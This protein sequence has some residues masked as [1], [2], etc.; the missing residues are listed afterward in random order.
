MPFISDNLL[1]DLP[2]HKPLENDTWPDANN[3]KLIVTAKNCDSSSLDLL[4]SCLKIK[5]QGQLTFPSQTRDQIISAIKHGLTIEF[6]AEPDKEAIGGGQK[7]MLRGPVTIWMQGNELHWFVGKESSTQSYVIQDVAGLNHWAIVVNTTVDSAR[8]TFFKDGVEITNQAT[9]IP[10]TESL[11]DELVATAA[12]ELAIGAENKGWTGKL[13]HL[14]IWGTPLTKDQIEQ[15]IQRD[16]TAHAAFKATTRIEWRLVNAIDEPS[17][18][19][20]SNG[21]QELRLELGNATQGTTLVIPH[22]DETASS[23]KYHFCLVFRPGTISSPL[24]NGT[25]EQFIKNIG[26]KNPDWSVCLDKLDMQ[27]CI[28]FLWKGSDKEL[29]P[30]EKFTLLIPGV[31]AEPGSG[32]R[33][34]EVGLYYKNLQIKDSGLPNLD[35]NRAQ[36]LNILYRESSIHNP[37]L[38]VGVVGAPVVL[39]NGGET[40]LTL[41]V[42]NIKRDEDQNSDPLYFGSIGQNND[43]SP[44]LIL[45][46]EIIQPSFLALNGFADDNDFAETSL[47][48][49]FCSLE[50]TIKGEKQGGEFAWTILPKRV[51]SNDKVG[52]DADETVLIKL[53]NLKTTAPPGRSVLRLCYEDFD[54]YGEGE[55]EIP[56]DRVSVIPA[57]LTQAGGAGYG[58]AIGHDPRV[59]KDTPNAEALNEM[60][61]IKKVDGNGDAVLIEN[62]GNGTGLNVVQRDNGVL[63]A[64]FSGGTGVEITG[65]FIV[66]STNTCPGNVGI[67]IAP[68]SEKLKVQGNTAI[69]GN[70]SATTLSAAST[71]TFTGNVGIGIE[72]GSEKLTVQGNTAILGN[73]SATTL[74]AT[75]TS[76]FTGNV[77][78]GIAPGSET[79]KVQGNTAITGNFS[80]FSGG[81]IGIGAT[82]LDKEP[83]VI[84]AQGNQE[85]LIAFENPSGQK[86]WHIE[87]NYDGNNPG[88]NFVE[89]G[90][91]DFRLFLKAGGNIGI[92]TS[93]PQ[94]KLH[95]KDGNLRIDSGE[96]KSCRPITLIPDID[97]TGDKEVVI[98]G[99]LKV[100]GEIWSNCYGDGWQKIRNA[101]SKDGQDFYM[102]RHQHWI[103]EPS[104]IQLKKSIGFIPDALSQVTRLKPIS[105]YW[106][107][108]DYLLNQSDQDVPNEQKQTE[109]SQEKAA[110]KAELEKQQ[111]GFI[112]Q[113]LEEIFPDWVSTNTD[114]YKQIN[115]RMLPSFLVRSIQELKQKCDDLEVENQ[116]LTSRL[117]TLEKRLEKLEERC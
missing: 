48:H 70:L 27:D 97:N 16:I 17:L 32:S 75:S 54:R 61:S 36:R 83:L 68:S 19:I 42:K 6:W 2:F 18:Y 107:N 99:K 96:I 91:A 57:K 3:P 101:T 5:A 55:F 15:N 24:L 34:T 52:L 12:T 77:G 69:L 22:S 49:Q 46:M 30:Q 92:G 78:I 29:K 14:R 33:P 76:T 44:K 117:E 80:V 51:I 56:I 114:G 26:A 31:A 13:A 87:Q 64:K 25:A 67:G 84:R 112:A 74:S 82:T 111:F 8:I 63:A 35:G 28:C 66:S 105:F 110:L 100:E 88:L 47:T 20:H 90:I 113:D 116:H 71:S 10:L 9:S 94:E 37:P 93:N 58:L 79:L 73:L 7:Y 38:E 103:W 81:R 40:C 86:K 1:L 85:G 106:K 108:P 115:L 41:Y 53:T 102:A 109:V 4:G 23:Q 21:S 60:V 50:E 11:E 39:N 45:K 98:K 59:D 65:N 62:S 104:D 72:S 89:T 95:I 43:A